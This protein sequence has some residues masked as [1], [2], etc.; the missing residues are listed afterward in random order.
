MFDRR[1][2]GLIVTIQPRDEG[3]GGS[4][5]RRPEVLLGL[6]H[7]CDS[8]FPIGSF[9]HSDGLESAV[10]AG[11]VA[12]PDDLTRWLEVCRDES[13][14]RADGPA[15]LIAQVALQ[16][17]DFD[18]LVEVDE[19]LT[20][21]RPSSTARAASRAMGLRLLKT[22]HAT[23]PDVRLER[24]LALCRAQVLGPT[25]PVAFAAVAECIGAAAHETLA[26]YAYT[27]L[28]A[29]ISTAMRLFPIG[30]GEAHARLSRALSGVPSVIDEV[31][32]R[33]ERPAS[34]APAFD[35][36]QMTQQYVH[37]RLFKS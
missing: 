35:I 37:A 18:A 8:L 27:R 4:A 26:A 28:A 13:F 9:G 14:G 2:V 25:L 3:A 1:S 11:L 21:L 17:A 12:G 30:Q 20:A 7:V 5:T 34:F 36:A 10:N 29:T 15:M 33:Q 23:V 31:L 6:L 24:L 22:W 19:E 32:A 16:G